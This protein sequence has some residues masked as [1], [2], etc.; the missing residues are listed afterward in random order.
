M[1]RVRGGFHEGLKTCGE[2]FAYDVR[3]RSL[4]GD[5]REDLESVHEHFAEPEPNRPRA[6]K[7]ATERY[8]G[9]FDWK[10]ELAINQLVTTAR[11]NAAGWSTTRW[12]S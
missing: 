5:A 10:Y 6:L 7:G 4:S 9:C 8:R 3:E 11:L 12:R 2:T 1:D